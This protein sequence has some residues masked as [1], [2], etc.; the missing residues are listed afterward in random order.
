V[1]GEKEW[2]IDRCES[3]PTSGSL[4]YPLRRGTPVVPEEKQWIINSLF[5]G[6]DKGVPPEKVPP[7]L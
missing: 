7:T 3:D 1:P 2:I 6:P 5:V 4:R